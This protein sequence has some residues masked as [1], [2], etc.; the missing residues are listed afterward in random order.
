MK[1]RL[2]ALAFGII[3]ILSFAAPTVAL[4]QVCPQG[5]TAVRVGYV[6]EPDERWVPLY[7]CQKTP[8]T[9]AGGGGTLA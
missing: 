5:Y 1:N 7:Q 8:G 4:A 2:I 6:Q 3:T 9:G